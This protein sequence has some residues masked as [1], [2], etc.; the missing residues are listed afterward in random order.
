MDAG[1][2]VENE[3]LRQQMQ[4]LA[5]FGQRNA[6]RF[7]DR[8]AHVFAADLAGARAERDAALAVDAADM[9]ARDADN[10]MLNR[11]LRDVLRLLDRF[12]DGGDRLVEIGDDALAHAAR[13]GRCRGRDSARRSR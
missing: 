8:L 3:L 6:A 13:V 4:R 5:I 2:V 1:L 9:R 11:R 7:L 10:G 12:L